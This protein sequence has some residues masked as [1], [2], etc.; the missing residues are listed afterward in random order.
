[1]DGAFVQA[2]LVDLTGLVELVGSIGGV[3][4]LDG[5]GIEQL[6]VLVPV[7]RVF[8]ERFFVALH[9]GGHGVAAVV[10]HVLIVHRLHAVRS[11]QRIYQILR[12]RIHID[13]KVVKIGDVV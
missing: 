2:D 1:M 12:Q 9:I 4:N 10:P 11:A 13:G 7:G 8:G 6:A 5:D 3:D